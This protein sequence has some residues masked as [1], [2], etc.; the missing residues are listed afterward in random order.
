[1]VRDLPIT[2]SWS[3]TLRIREYLN[4]Q[5]VVEPGAEAYF[6]KDSQTTTSD[7]SSFLIDAPAI[8]KTFIVELLSDGSLSIGCGAVTDQ[9]D[10]SWKCAAASGMSE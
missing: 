10:A 9:K 3:Q 4:G 7:G 5:T 1:M 8:K 6:R 2:V